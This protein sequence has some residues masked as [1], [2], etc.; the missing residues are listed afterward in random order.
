MN[1]VRLVFDQS[2]FEA[3]LRAV[4]VEAFA[5]LTSNVIQKSPDVCGQ[6]TVF[7]LDV[8]RFDSKPVARFFG[9]VVSDCAGP[10]TA[11]VL[12]ESIDKPKAG[13]DHMRR[14]VHG[15]H[16]FPVL[17]PAVHILWM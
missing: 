2:P 15:N 1:D 13:A 7:D 8:A 10:E 12:G 6:V 11:H 4:H 3:F 16:S 5:V 17:R 14:V 9:N